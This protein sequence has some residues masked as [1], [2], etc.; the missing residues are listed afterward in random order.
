MDNENSTKLDIRKNM[1]SKTVY[2][3]G[4]LGVVLF[5]TSSILDGLLIEDYDPLRHEEARIN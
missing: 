3:I 5:A 1:N 2:R 4:I